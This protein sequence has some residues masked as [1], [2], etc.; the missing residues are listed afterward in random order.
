MQALTQTP[1]DLDILRRLKSP[2]AVCC[3]LN[4]SIRTKI[5]PRCDFVSLR[6][7]GSSHC[8]ETSSWL[9]KDGVFVCAQK[10]HC[11]FISLSPHQGQV[12]LLCTLK[13]WK[14]CWDLNLVSSIRTIFCF[15]FA[16]PSYSSLRGL[17]VLFLVF[18]Q[19]LLW[20]SPEVL[21]FMV[22]QATDQFI[23][24]DCNSRNCSLDLL[25]KVSMHQQW[26]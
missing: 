19:H 13:Y 9:P 8:P 10:P 7:L 15:I 24:N 2:G 16:F 22:G 6:H 17:T 5:T 4:V 23:A 1:W 20:Q 11:M 14:S 12:L 25:A 26:Q 3:A 21:G 18:S